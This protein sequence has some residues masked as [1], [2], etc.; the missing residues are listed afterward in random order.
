M[1][2]TADSVTAADAAVTA[3]HGTRAERFGQGALPGAGVWA[4]CAAAALLL[5]LCSGL[6]PH[7]IWGVPATVGYAGAAWAAARG[8]RRAAVVGAAGFAV[9]LPLLMLVLMERAQ[10][11]VEV[12]ARSAH[13]LLATGSPYAPDPVAV[14]DFDPYLPAMSVFGIPQALLGAGPLTDPRLWT[15]A[16]FLGALALCA[17]R[18]SSLLVLAACPVVALP[19]A[20]GGVD[21]PVVASMCLGLSSA[22]RGRPVAAGLAIG[23]AAA[24]KWTAWPA[25]PVAVALLVSMRQKGAAL[26]CALVAMSLTAALVLPVALRDTSSFAEHVVAYPLGLTDA[27]SPAASPF[28]GHLLAAGVP[29]GRTVALVLL[30][31]CA[32]AVAGSLIVRP[33]GTASD[34]ALRLALGL[35][36]AIAL[37]PATRFGYLVYPLV[38]TVWAVS[39]R[40]RAPHDAAARPQGAPR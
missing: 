36:L 2:A 24:L 5:A 33:P 25:L 29:G 4:G 10:L 7:R 6:A 18:S 17:G 14:A 23:F 20:V 31:C 8:R 34:A 37:M 12:V 1:D 9:G 39:Q 30:L 3:R 26:R 35:C 38:L 27:L 15:G 21:L 19:L 32:L 40:D 11:E 13:A 28:P 16:A 22:G